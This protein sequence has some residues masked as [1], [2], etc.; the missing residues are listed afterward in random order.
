MNRQHNTVLF[1]L[2]ATIFNVL[3]MVFYFLMFQGL[4]SLFLPIRE[5]IVFVALGIGD[6]VAA[7]AATWFTYRAIFRIL[8]DKVPL[9][10]Y[11]DQDLFKGLF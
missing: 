4:G 2:G 5:G 3:L 6:F 9:D 1:L 10:R 11:F 8:K 7:I